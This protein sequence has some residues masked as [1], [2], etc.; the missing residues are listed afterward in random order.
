MFSQLR[1][2]GKQSCILNYVC[3]AGTSM[4]V[5]KAQTFSHACNGAIHACFVHY[6]FETS[7]TFWSPRHVGDSTSAAIL[8]QVQREVIRKSWRDPVQVRK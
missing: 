6:M 2:S 7:T 4:F 1:Y 5:S 8:G 3:W